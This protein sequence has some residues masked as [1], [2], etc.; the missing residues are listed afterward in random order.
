MD[1]KVYGYV[2]INSETGEQWGTQVYSGKAGAANSY[3]QVHN[4]AYNRELRHKFAD[5]TLF[6]RKEL[7][8]SE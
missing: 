4:N 5:Q 1:K 7:V 2:I 8:L 6:V 3:N